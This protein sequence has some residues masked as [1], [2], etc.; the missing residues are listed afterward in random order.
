MKVELTNEKLIVGKYPC[1]SVTIT[2]ENNGYV[3]SFLL[4]ATYTAKRKSDWHGTSIITIPKRKTLKFKKLE[5]SGLELKDVGISTVAH[6]GYKKYL[7]A[8]NNKGEYINYYET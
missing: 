1:S 2:K 7:S 6:L 3:A 5:Y 8:E 4:L